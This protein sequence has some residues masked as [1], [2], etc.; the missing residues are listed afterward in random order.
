VKAQI[1]EVDWQKHNSN[2]E[3]DKQNMKKHLF[4]PKLSLFFVP[5]TVNEK[6]ENIVNT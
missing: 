5:E 2:S 6:D 3:C 4:L 1:E